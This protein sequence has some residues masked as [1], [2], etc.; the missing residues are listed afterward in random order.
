MIRRRRGTVFSA[1][2]VDRIR[3]LWSEGVPVAAIC[4]ILCVTRDTFQARRVD[5]LAD[6]PERVRGVGGRFNR[7]ADPS[8]DEI[9]ER[10]AEIRASWSDG[11][12][13]AR[14]VGGRVPAVGE[15]MVE[16]RRIKRV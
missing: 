14:M 13:W 1:D 12:R 15:R 2:E 11:E 5:Q 16:V 9:A 10:A 3:S 7:P 4:E 8:E 6:L